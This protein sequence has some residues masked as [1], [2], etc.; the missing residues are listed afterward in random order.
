MQWL[1]SRAKFY[2]NIIDMLD[3]ELK[4]SGDSKKDSE[5]NLRALYALFPSTANLLPRQVNFASLD[6]F[7]DFSPV[8]SQ[9][10]PTLGKTSKGMSPWL[11]PLMYLCFFYLLASLATSFYKS[12]F[13][14]VSWSDEICLALMYIT[15]AVTNVP[16]MNRTMALIY[17]GLVVVSIV[18]DIVWF[19]YYLSV[20]FA[21]TA[22]VEHQLH[23]LQLPRRP[24]RLHHHHG[25]HPLARQ[26]KL[27][28]PDLLHRPHVF[29]SP[30]ASY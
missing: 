6:R 2:S 3:R 9:T 7:N 23:R 22:L 8:V 10:E 1:Y 30:V 4:T 16:R 15:S 11:T 28:S 17:I 20:R 14:D 13:L 26:S 18:L 27:R 19:I 5:E 21:Q 25:A 12:Q 29:A 24:P